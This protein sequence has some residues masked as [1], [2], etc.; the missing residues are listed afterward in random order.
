MCELTRALEVPN[1]V[2][3][4]TSS[5][6]L[7]RAS[8]KKHTIYE[9]EPT[10]ISNK[11]P[12]SCLKKRSEVTLTLISFDRFCYKSQVYLPSLAYISLIIILGELNNGKFY[13]YLFWYPCNHGKKVLTLD[14]VSF[15]S[16]LKISHN[17]YH[18][19]SS[20]DYF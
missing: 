18:P 14:P 17:L 2:N 13:F 4:S 11:I 9:E 19:I 12:C 8:T 5:S 10:A 15:C 3:F 7:D 1:N 20:F 16:R 6:V